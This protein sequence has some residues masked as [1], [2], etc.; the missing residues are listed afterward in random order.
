MTNSALYTKAN[1]ME[2]GKTTWQRVIAF[3]MRIDPKFRPQAVTEPESVYLSRVAR[4]LIKAPPCIWHHWSCD[5]ERWI[6]KACYAIN[7]TEAVPAP[8]GFAANRH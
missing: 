4:T 5:V 2:T 1:S 8:K 3:T 7:M 6:N